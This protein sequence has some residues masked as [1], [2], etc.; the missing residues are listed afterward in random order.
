[1]AHISKWVLTIDL[2]FKKTKP[3]KQQHQQQKQDLGDACMHV[4][5]DKRRSLTTV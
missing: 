3:K 5:N 2:L 4:T 1:M